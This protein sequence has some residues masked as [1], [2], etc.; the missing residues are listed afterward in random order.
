MTTMT[1]KL[2]V[3]EYRQRLVEYFTNLYNETNVRVPGVKEIKLEPREAKAVY[4]YWNAAHKHRA[5]VANEPLLIIS[6]PD[7]TLEIVWRLLPNE[8]CVM[9]VTWNGRLW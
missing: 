9:K 4:T 2:T 3:R 7:V 6:L 8:H 1:T 5:M